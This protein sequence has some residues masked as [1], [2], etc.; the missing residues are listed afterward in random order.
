MAG[1]GGGFDGVAVRACEDETVVH[2]LFTGLLLLAGLPVAVRA[3]RGDAGGR[4]D[5]AAFRADGLGRQG[6]EPAGPGALEGAA[7]ACGAVVEVEVFP[8]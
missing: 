3:E 6:G 5:D 2:P 1:E 4:E 7:D 8:A